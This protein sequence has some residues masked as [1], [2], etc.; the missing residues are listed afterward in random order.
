M[1]KKNVAGIQ[2]PDFSLMITEMNYVGTVGEIRIP[3]SYIN[4]FC[5]A[6]KYAVS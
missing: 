6:Q 4:D 5:F 1:F 3:Y 2:C